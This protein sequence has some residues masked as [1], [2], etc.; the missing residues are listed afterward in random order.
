MMSG[1][2]TSSAEWK[3]VQLGEVAEF[4]NG[5]IYDV[6]SGAYPVKVIGVGDF[7]NNFEP[8][9]SA[10]RSVS[11]SA[12]LRDDD[13]LSPDDLLFVRSNGNK[14]LIGRCMIIRPTPE[15]I[16]Y[17][18]FTIRARIVVDHLLPEFVALF[19]QTNTARDRIFRH[20]T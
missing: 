2:R 5:L 9:V 7:G 13:Y 6:V 1:L 16:S 11:L 4:K 18:G 15:R 12:P 17:S 14:R 10:L 19:M 3:T 8:D 20:G